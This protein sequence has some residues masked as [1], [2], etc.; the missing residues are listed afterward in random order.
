MP[1]ADLEKT[2]REMLERIYQTVSAH[3]PP[4]SK[5]D[6]IQNWCNILGWGLSPIRS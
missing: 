2:R 4:N 6:T 1:D 3:I 5:A